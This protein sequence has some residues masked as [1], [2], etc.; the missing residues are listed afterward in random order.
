MTEAVC[1]R[2]SQETLMEACDDAAASRGQDHAYVYP[3]KVLCEVLC[4]LFFPVAPL[5]IF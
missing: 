5:Y 4:L 2:E 3:G 1:S